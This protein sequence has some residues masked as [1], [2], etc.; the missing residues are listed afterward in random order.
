MDGSSW[1]SNS[2]PAMTTSS[3]VTS[4]KYQQSQSMNPC[5]ISEGHVVQCC[6]WPS[7]ELKNCQLNSKDTRFKHF[8]LLRLMESTVSCIMANKT[9]VHSTRT[10]SI[11]VVLDPHG[12]NDQ[13]K[14]L[15]SL[16]SAIRQ[17]FIQ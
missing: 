9:Y 6:G 16:V 4:Y 10:R 3:S 11:I 15:D 2:V 13:L 12:A 17:M 14:V 7:L 5:S 1:R 8:Q